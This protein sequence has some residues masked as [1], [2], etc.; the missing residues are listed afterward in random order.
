VLRPGPNAWCGAEG[1]ARLL[2]PALD[3]ALRGLREAHGNDPAAWRWGAAHVAAF[4]HPLLRFIPVLRDLTRL[5]AATGGD[6]ETLARGGMRGGDG[7]NPFAH[8]HGA[9][10]RGVF[11]LA[12]PDGILVMIATGQSGHPLSDR[13]G[14]LLGRW[15]AGEMLR[16]TRQ[17]AVERGRIE[18]QP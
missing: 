4:E 8:L 2:A 12:D 7:T 9:G 5:E 13:Y 10:F 11:D 18:L 17:P 1:C 6:G 3:V 14:D 16:L 15:Q